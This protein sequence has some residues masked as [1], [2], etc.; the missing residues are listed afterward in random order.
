M[1]ANP[2]ARPRRGG[3][4]AGARA[5]GGC[6]CGWLMHVRLQPPLPL[7]PLLGEWAHGVPQGDAEKK[8]LKKVFTDEDNVMQSAIRYE[9]RA[10]HSTLTEELRGDSLASKSSLL[11]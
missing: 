10:D 5:R 7:E 9:Q 3:G 6:N 4:A 2:I 8:R 11:G 1:W